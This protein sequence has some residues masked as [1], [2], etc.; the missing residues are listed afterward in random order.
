MLLS[1]KSEAKS[2]SNVTK[3]KGAN[4]TAR[5]RGASAEEASGESLKNIALIL[6]PVVRPL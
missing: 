5:G 4:L 3:C 2:F 6:M 1:N